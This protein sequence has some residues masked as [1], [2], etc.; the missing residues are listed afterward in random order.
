MLL[1]P[2]SQM[3]VKQKVNKANSKQ[4]AAPNPQKNE[5]DERKE[6]V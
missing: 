5:E 4:S 2:T 3:E 6:E 1:G